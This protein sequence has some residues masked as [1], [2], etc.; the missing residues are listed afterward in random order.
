M[1]MRLNV[2]LGERPGE[3][4]ELYSLADVV[5][6]ACG[7]HAGDE[8][9]M[10]EACR[11]AQAAGG[12]VAAHPSHPDRA[13][14][15]RREVTMAPDALAD[16]VAGQCAALAGIAA[17]YGLSVERMKPHG[18]LYHAAARDPVVAA[19]LLDGTT[20]GLGRVAIVGPAAGALR[21]LA[22]ERDLVYERECFA[23]RAT[24]PD[25]TLVPR[26]DPG[27]LIAEPAAA[28]RVAAAFRKDGGFETICVHS[29][30]P[31]AVAI[32]RAVRA[33]LD[34]R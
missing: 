8:A 15:G 17:E 14:F 5:N 20:R 26:S 19:A 3:P 28:A 32:A 21:T 31:E 16:A 12:A 2:D 18:A 24:R 7:G 34:A 9:S 30:T 23:D 33:V 13:G 25:G 10:R 4:E 6:V 22:L 1:T 27:A 11:R 29:D